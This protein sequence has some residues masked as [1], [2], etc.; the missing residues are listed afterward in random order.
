VL[1]RNKL[2]YTMLAK[3]RRVP[4]PHR[5][6]AAASGG[7]VVLVAARERRGHAG[8]HRSRYVREFTGH[9]RIVNLRHGRNG[10]ELREGPGRHAALTISRV[11][12][13]TLH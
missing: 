9:A 7:V 8:G 1:L 6:G 3:A 13:L 11:A 10:R 2:V 12:L 5:Y 4:G